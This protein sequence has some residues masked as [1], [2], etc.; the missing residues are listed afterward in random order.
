MHG[1]LEAVH[2]KLGEVLCEP[3]VETSHVYFPNDSLVSL[4]GVAA[5][6]KALEVGMIGREGMFGFSLAL[7]IG[8]SPARALV[9]GSGTAMRM[10]AASF[11]REL[12]RN[13]WLLE[14]ASRCAH[15]SMTTAMQVAAC[16]NAHVLLQRFARWLLMTSDCT[17]HST[18][19]LTQEFLALMAGVRRT[20]VTEAAG[21]LQKR[22]I[23]AY[24]RGSI[25]ILK[26]SE[27]EEASCGCYAAIRRMSR[28]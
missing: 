15:I 21:I 22:G 23:I 9:Q 19:F 3:Y 4:L 10:S 28:S 18:L 20:G 2:L 13:R 12:K 17:G 7:G 24:R 5:G 25:T 8:T 11:R 16:N 26:R 27:L 1:R 6:G 14:G